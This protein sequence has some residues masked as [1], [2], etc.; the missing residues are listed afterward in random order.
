MDWETHSLPNLVVSQIH[1]LPDKFHPNTSTCVNIWPTSLSRR[2][3]KVLTKTKNY[4][5]SDVKPLEAPATYIANPRLTTQSRRS[6]GS[7]HLTNPKSL[8]KLSIDFL[9]QQHGVW[10]RIRRRYARAAT[11]DRP[12]A[13]PQDPLTLFG[14]AN[15]TGP[16]RCFPFWQEVLACYVVNADANDASGARKCSPA[17]E[18]YYECL[19]H[20]KEVTTDRRL[21]RDSCHGS[22]RLYTDWLLLGH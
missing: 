6:C 3:L 19:H 16:G 18:D 14:V 4:R 17:L 2:R 9:S 20:K 7:P 13:L 11:L 15:S 21:G 5:D 12:T 1:L 10:L 22:V 8:T